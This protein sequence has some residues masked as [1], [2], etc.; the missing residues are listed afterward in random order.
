MYIDT[1]CHLNFVAFKDDWK[2]TAD[3]CVKAGVKKMIVVGADL[4]TSARAVEICEQHPAL[5]AAVG[6]H[7]HHSH[8]LRGI[9]NFQFSIFKKLENLAKSKKV[10]AIGECGLDYH[11]YKKTKYLN[12]EITPEVKTLQKRLF[13]QQ[14][15]LAKKLELPMIIHNRA[16]G[17]ET[18]DTLKHFCAGDGQYPR[19]VFHCISGSKKLL[20]KIL[21][22]DFYIGIDGNITY[23]QEVQ[24]LATEAPLERILLETD[25]P[26]LSPKHD[27]SRNF[28]QSVK[29]A[30]Q[31]LAKLKSTS[32]NQIEAETTKNAEKLF[33]L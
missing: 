8:A 30:A 31:F 23:S 19:G 22:L 11:V 5:F 4:E 15:Q 33:K 28:P 6:V 1:H 14:I 26:Y 12:E 25:A 9:T 16:A 7:P 2:E 13:G 21:D 17:E 29:I 10:V 32:I 20:T 18:L 3:Q 24:T 27:G